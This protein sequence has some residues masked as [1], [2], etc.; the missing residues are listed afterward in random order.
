MSARA[1]RVAQRGILPQRQGRRRGFRHAAE[2]HHESGFVRLHQV[3]GERQR[4]GDHRHPARHVL[5]DLGRHRVPEVRVVLQQR[6]PRQRAVHDQHG[7]VVGQEPVPAQHPRR[8][9]WLQHRAGLGVGRAHQLHDEAMRLHEPG[10]FRHLHCPPVRGDVPHVHQPAAAVVGRGL[11]RHVGG[12]RH[13][14]VRP[15]ETLVVR[16]L[17]QDQVQPPL[18]GALGD[19][20][21]TGHEPAQRGR[22][23][24]LGAQRGGGV[25]VHVPDR[26]RAVPDQ[27]QHQQ[28]FGVVEEQ[29]V[30]ARGVPGQ[31]GTGRAQ[32]PEPAPP[33]RPWHLGQGQARPRGD[34]AGAQRRD[35]GDLMPGIKQRADLP[36]QDP[37][38]G[39]MVHHGADDDA[40]AAATASRCQG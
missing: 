24:C 27:R 20:D 11:L 19:T 18:R 34:V 7:L 2:R 38:V 40:H 25:L 6:Q 36:V 21:R 9:R 32:R 35:V 8:A 15:G 33:D 28:Q 12:V 37:G 10:Q 1:H 13:D 3:H 4:R 30:R 17:G 39:R 31:L 29:H 23:P 22:Q 26:R 5:R 14:R 16:P